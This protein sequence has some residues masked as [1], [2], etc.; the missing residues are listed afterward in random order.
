[1]SILNFLKIVFIFCCFSLNSL[2][3][4]E[5]IIIQTVS[6]SKRSFA[7]RKGRA[8]GVFVG[9]KSLFSSKDFSFTAQVTKVNREYS[10]WELQDKNA[11]VPFERNQVVNYTNSIDKV[12]TEL[13][14]LKF[15]RLVS[16]Q[17]KKELKKSAVNLMI[18]GNYAKTFSESISEVD[19]SQTPSRV[20]THFEGLYLHY[21]SPIY[22]LA[23]GIRYDID[24]STKESSGA[25][26]PPIDIAS[27]RLFAIAE[28][29]YHFER[30][31]NSRNH[32]FVTVGMGFGTSA[33]TV[34]EETKTGAASILP[35]V[36]LGFESWPKHADYRLF[37]EL[38]AETIATSESFED[39]DEQ[40][41][42]IN[43]VKVAVGIKF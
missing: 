10:V 6:T 23:F 24:V 3:N 11:I 19:S 9:Q 42:N 31:K 13:S 36:R 33:T 38:V 37:A 1:M 34:N 30:M 2:A 27:K 41:T 22:S 40:T 18:R 16:E 28:A 12:W 26:N 5:L 39:G 4:D 29:T 20:G 15:Q 25:D 14:Y 32:F 7:I 8:T 43:N 21:L 17:I 35:N